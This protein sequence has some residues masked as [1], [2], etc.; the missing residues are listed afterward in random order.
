MPLDAFRTHRDGMPALPHGS[1]ATLPGA[2]GASNPQGR[3]GLL[4]WLGLH[5]ETLQMVV[6]PVEHRLLFGAKQ[7]EQLDVLVAHCATVGEVAVQD[8]EL[9]PQ[10]PHAYAHDDPSL[11]QDVQRGDHFG[12]EHGVAVGQHLHADAKAHPLGDARQKGQQG[13]GLEDVVV[14]VEGGYTAG[15]VRVP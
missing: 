10:P 4:H 1:G 2:G 8:L 15:V 6:L 11:G 7:L 12:V 3:V 5:F 14:G 9:L 13:E